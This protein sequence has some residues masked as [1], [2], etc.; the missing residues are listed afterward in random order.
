MCRG[1]RQGG[2]GPEVE[3]GGAIKNTKINKQMHAGVVVCIWYS[4]GIYFCLCFMC[5]SEKQFGCGGRIK[6]GRIPAFFRAK[7][8]KVGWSSLRVGGVAWEGVVLIAGLDPHCVSLGWVREM[9]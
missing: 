3:Q 5:H 8:G 7:G 2:E 6:H 9:G 4:F 1:G